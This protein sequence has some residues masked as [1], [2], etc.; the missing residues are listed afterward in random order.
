MEEKRFS[1]EFETLE[2][3]KD[4]ETDYLKKRGVKR[5]GNREVYKIEE[6]ERGIHICGGSATRY[7]FD[8]KEPEELPASRACV[9]LP[10]EFLPQLKELIQETLGDKPPKEK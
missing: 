5:V 3:I 8:D 7:Y 1:R 2:K 9:L 4:A 10:R 6:T